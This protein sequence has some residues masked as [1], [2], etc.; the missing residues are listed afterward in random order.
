MIFIHHALAEAFIE[1]LD[2]ASVTLLATD[3]PYYGIVEETWDNQWSFPH[4]YVDWLVTLLEMF[5]R[6]L[7]PTGSIV[8]FQ[9]FGKHGKHPVFDVIQRLEQTYTFRNVITWKKRRAYGKE[10]DYLYCREEI[11]WFSKSPERTE[12][13][14]NIPLTNQLRGYPG[15]SKKYPAK[16]EFKRVSNVWDDIPELFTP[17]RNAQKPIELMERIVK[18]HSNPGDLVVDLF[19]GW[20]TTGVAALKNGRNFIGCEG[21]A[22]DAQAANERC[23][24]V[25]RQINLIMNDR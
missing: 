14:F 7:T 13:V 8:F 6:K 12:V 22:A 20:G 23:T 11:L 16:S 2:D 9:G 19:C 4:A 17:E 24:A 25:S 3:P 15:Y 21:I 5:K 1:T 10:F 18:T